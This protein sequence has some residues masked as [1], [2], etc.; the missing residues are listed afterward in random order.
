MRLIVSTGTK[1]EEPPSDP[2]MGKD[3]Q[4]DADTSTKEWTQNV[5]GEIVQHDTKGA[6]ETIEGGANV[7]R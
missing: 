3:V 2:N 7:S 4:A 6:K 1:R 5:E